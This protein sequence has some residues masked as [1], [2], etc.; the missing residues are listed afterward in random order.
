[1]GQ[2]FIEKLTPDNVKLKKKLLD[3]Y[4][5]GNGLGLRPSLRIKYDRNRLKFLFSVSYIKYCSITYKI[6][7]LNH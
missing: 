6:L 5:K 4:L 7:V 1:M 3:M 2:V